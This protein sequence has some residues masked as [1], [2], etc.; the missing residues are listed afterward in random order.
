MVANW[1]YDELILAADLL[2][3]NGW[4]GVRATNPVAVKLSNLLRDG[5]L[6]PGESLPENFRSPSSIQ[7][8]TYDI[9]T[10]DPSYSGKPT[11]HGPYD[12]QIAVAFRERPDEMK[13]RAAAIR[14]ALE[15]GEA[16][17]GNSDEFWL[18]DVTAGEGGI[19]EYLARKRERDRGIRADKIR[20][21]QLAG[22]ALS[23]EAC[24]FDFGAVYGERGAGYVEVHHV[25]PLHVSGPTTTS[26][27]DL[28]LLCANCH[29]MCHRGALITPVEVRQLVESMHKTANA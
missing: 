17:P 10:A 26:L 29:R 14:A 24:G 6:H 25:V 20:A 19:L 11:R 23:C 22:G 15:S 28:A 2:A 4:V 12:E 27:S 21:V 7:R 3:Q 8:K 16:L 1:T 18:D 9:M 13:A 5:Q